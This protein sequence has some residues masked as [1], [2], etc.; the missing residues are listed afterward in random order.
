MKEEGFSAQTGEQ[1]TQATMAAEG[2]AGLS[3]GDS[4][5][6]DS[7]LERHVL[8]AAD[9]VLQGGVQ[10]G[11]I[12]GIVVL[13][14]PELL[15]LA[16]G[17]G[18]GGAGAQVAGGAGAQVAGGAGAQVAGGVRFV[19]VGD[20][21]VIE[22][23]AKTVVVE[24][25]FAASPPPTLIL[26]SG[27]QLS[28]SLVA[29]FLEQGGDFPQ[30]YALG[31][32][33]GKFGMTD[34]NGGMQVIGKIVS[35]EGQVW[36]VRDG[37]VIR[38]EAGDIVLEGDII[39][40]GEGAEVFMR[41]TD[42]MEFRLGE[43]ARLA[44][45]Q[46]LYDDVSS[47]GLQVL[48]IIAGA[49]SYASGLLAGASPISVRLQT[50]HGVIGIR[51]TKILGE[52]GD[53]GLVVT[54]LEGRVALLQEGREVA[55]LDEPF[56]TLRIDSAAGVAAGATN[57]G[58]NGDAS[59][60]SG[61][62]TEIFSVA[63]VLQTYDFLDGSEQQLRA[64]GAG[65]RL[66]DEPIEDAGGNSGSDSGTD[67]GGDSG[68]DNGEVAEVA[69]LSGGDETYILAPVVREEA[70][71]FIDAED[72]GGLVARDLVENLDAVEVEEIV[73]EVEEEIVEEIVEEEIADYVFDARGGTDSVTGSG[74]KIVFVGEEYADA[75]YTFTRPDSSSEAV[76]LMVGYS[77]IE[78][79]ILHIVE[80]TSDPSSVYDFY[81]RSGD[82]D[83]P[84]LASELGVVPA[85]VVVEGDGSATNP[86]LAT[87]AADTITGSVDND[88]VSYEEA[89][90]GVY[91]DLDTP[92]RNSGWAAGDTLTG[93]NNLIG[94]DQGDYLSGTDEAHILRG[95]AG[96]DALY[97]GDGDDLLEGGAGNDELGGG[98]G[99]DTLDGG[100]GDEDRVFY[101]A[102]GKGVRVDLSLATAQK[103]FEVNTF[104]FVA[105]SN[106]AVGDILSNIESIYGSSHNDWLTG[107]GGDN[108]L[109]GSHG[110]DRL[111]G[112]AGADTIDGGAGVDTAS[113]TSSSNGVRVSLLLQGQ[114]Q[115]D[116]EANSFG[117]AANNNDAEG[118]ILTSIENIEGSI[119][120]DWLTGD[121]ADNE[122]RGGAGND[123]LEGGVG[124]DTYLFIAGD[125]TDSVTDSGGK[126]VFVGDEYA[127]ATY[128]FT[129]PD[130]S[131][132]AVTLTVKDSGGNRLNVLE[133]ASDPSSDYAF[134]T[135]SG[136]PDTDITASLPAVPARVVVE[137]DGS[138]SDP[139]LATAAADTITGSV[140]NDWVSY[141]EAPAGV[142]VDL[143]TP[144]YNEDW[145]EDDTLNNINNLIGS[146]HGDIL[147]G[148]SGDNILRGGAGEDTLHG[149][150]GADT[151]D[152]GAG[153]DQLIGGAGA[154]TLDGGEGTD[155][156]S[157][158]QSSKGVRVSLLLQGQAQQDF[159][160]N[161]FGFAANNNEAV[162]D[163]LSN[164]ERIHG[165]VY[166]DWLTGDGNA[167]TL[168]GFFGDDR[169]EGGAG[170]DELFGYSGNDR[171]YGGAGNDFLYGGADDDTLLGGADVDTY[172]FE[173]GDGTDTVTDDGGKIVFD[174]ETGNAYTG[175]TYTFTRPDVS[176][177]AVT[178]TVKDSGGNRLNVLEFASD[179]SL[180]YS[181]YTYDGGT[182]T[183]IPASE[184]V[185]PPRGDGS[186]SDPFLATADPD[187][188]SGTG[189]DGWVSYE[190][191]TSE[192]MRFLDSTNLNKGW[193]DGDTLLY[194]EN[195]IG[196]S[197]YKNYLSGDSDANTF[198][199]GDVDDILKGRV[200]DDTLEGGAGND[201]LDGGA[202]A[203]TLYGGTGTD[204][205][206]IHVGDGL[207]TIH[208]VAG[209]IMILQFNYVSYKGTDFT[210]TNNF[211]RVGNNLEITI[212]KNTGDG[213]TDKI[214]I[215]DAYDNDPNTGKGNSAFTINIEYGV[216]TLT[217]VANEFWHNLA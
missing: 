195:I 171:L 24:G 63:E 121:G 201:L 146:D 197:N 205:Y 23:G 86:F 90:A 29:S 44:I 1:G 213:I 138:E 78:S 12:E 57:G 210:D 80:F 102:S 133:F 207:D 38:L 66:E 27:G 189:N 202:G 96:G 91:V 15:S 35:T 67:A 114:A 33:Q 158:W 107:D 172:V 165:S 130:V 42:K 40:T 17:G 88:W 176:G 180:G 99:A 143:V 206:V 203:D 49:F 18:A 72:G 6:G 187:N 155:D 127:S 196:S 104:G 179:P 94:S 112:G 7:S 209:D 28:P 77:P 115:Q 125:G 10:G 30:K 211:N 136:V 31:W 124:E 51:G 168:W 37:L 87:A 169:I 36:V 166:A 14:L 16:S 43:D 191:A 190:G 183:A 217:E 39:S 56:E 194:I 4:S 122:I 161:T 134:Y 92:A 75:T 162:G 137:G 108:R 52:V 25:Y 184:L 188:F 198:R 73:V 208:D 113:Y 71:S 110:D 186:E 132:E 69:L 97:G 173:V 156:A 135:R 129:R 214:I 181:F 54:V 85:R 178:L 74:G 46:Y 153:S 70:R 34:D 182:N 141:E 119:F 148:N 105:N 144:T 193:A 9:A 120:N 58:A 109:Y 157:Y 32:L 76:T 81:T 55:V 150:A 50:P 177:E 142:Y 103:D 61:I 79:T 140:D 164:I 64:L 126:I 170:Y 20:D 106:E 68:G 159:E 53:E 111:E 93:I 89:P 149:G 11:A 204:I 139:F 212:D 62:R 48:S 3:S 215:L 163:I 8:S 175:A 59:G 47:S 128:T 98:A 101:G 147:S 83:T 192:I 185:V 45:D 22:A 21:L 174:Q 200:G 41:F 160:A 95:G 117:F 145:A 100:S 123:R 84:I 19:R 116:F 26:G 154:D 118:D 2:F 151:L 5:S 65:E 152:G 13:S 167:N 60:D 199:G 82:T 131:G 216:G